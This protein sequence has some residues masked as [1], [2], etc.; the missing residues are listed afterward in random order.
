MIAK[1]RMMEKSMDGDR[2]ETL[3]RLF[4]FWR[5]S[6]KEVYLYTENEGLARDMRKE[7]HPSATSARRG[8]AVGWRFTVN[9]T[10]VGWVS[11]RFNARADRL[12]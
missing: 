3:E 11:K 9:K 5:A 6:P 4:Y 2:G 12:S 10:H 1:E 7:L 8:V